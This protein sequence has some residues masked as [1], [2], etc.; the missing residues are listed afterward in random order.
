MEMV[1]GVSYFVTNRNAEWIKLTTKAEPKID[2]KQPKEYPHAPP[3]PMQ[4]R[5]TKR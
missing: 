4:M 3:R 1:A 2:D 5:H